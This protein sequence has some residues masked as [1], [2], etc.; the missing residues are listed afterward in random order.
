M[1]NAVEC[2]LQID[3][4]HAIKCLFAHARQQTV[5]R[6]TSVIDQNINA[7]P[8]CLH[9]CHHSCNLLEGGNISAYSLRFNTMHLGNFRRQVLCC[10]KALLT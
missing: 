7:A 8:H 6:D 3:I 2:A 9:L 1:A 5:T 4:D 10:L